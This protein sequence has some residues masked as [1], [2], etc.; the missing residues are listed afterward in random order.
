MAPACRGHILSLY[1][2]DVRALFAGNLHDS[3]ANHCLNTTARQSRR[4][5]GEMGHALG[6]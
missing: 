2:V 6:L 4:T 5:D 1:E 3:K